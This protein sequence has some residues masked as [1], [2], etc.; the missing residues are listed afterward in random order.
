MTTPVPSSRDDFPEPI[1]RALAARV[2]YRCS[3]PDCSA[4]TSGPQVEP[5]KALNVGVAAHITGAAPG[6]PRYDAT[7][8]PDERTDIAN[9]V[10]LCQTCAK[11]VD[12]DPARFS[13]AALRDWK[14]KA[15]QQALHLVGKTA[16]R[17]DV[18]V[19]IIDKWVNLPYPEKAGITQALNSEGYELRWTTAN[20]ESERV[21]LQGW[22]PVLLDQVDGTRARL[23]LRDHPVVGGYLIL[24]RKKRS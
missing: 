23:K 2:N 5:A 1:R 24:L 18:T 15:E 6:G 3:N 9:G 4:Q 21:D 7:L 12:N 19:P 14:T 22:E 20:E 17:H 10:W 13:A 11:L 16:P 8:T